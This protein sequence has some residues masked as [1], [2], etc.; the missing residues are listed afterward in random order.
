MNLNNLN[1]YEVIM[2]RQI[3]DIHSEGAML[4][5]K[6]S[7]A[8]VLLLSNDDDNKV[9]NIAFRTPVSTS[10]VCHISW[11]ILSFAEARN[12]RRRIHLSN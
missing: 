6:K 4:K 10:P 7:G 9:F 3:D 1:A 8:R 12:I 5:H 2:Q 11:S